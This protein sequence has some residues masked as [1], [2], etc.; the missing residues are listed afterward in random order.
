MDM[1][2]HVW[3]N[4]IHEVERLQTSSLSRTPASP[5]SDQSS[6]WS[7]YVR[8]YSINKTEILASA[9]RNLGLGALPWWVSVNPQVDECVQC[10]NMQVN[11]VKIV[12]IWNFIAE[13]RYNNL[14]PGYQNFSLRVFC[15]STMTL[16]GSHLVWFARFWNVQ[17]VP[18]GRS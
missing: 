11:G 8:I 12:K 2:M 10:R 1:C 5:S 3:I 18:Q 16:P 7:E 13:G 14:T 17:Q 6:W 15:S 4:W 9:A